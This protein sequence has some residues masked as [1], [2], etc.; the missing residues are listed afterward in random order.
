MH[1]TCCWQGSGRDE[2]IGLFHPLCLKSAAWMGSCTYPP[3]LLA[4][5]QRWMRPHPWGIHQPI[6]RDLLGR[7][8]AAGAA[9]VCPLLLSPQ[10]TCHQPGGTTEPRR[11]RVPFSH[12][13]GKS[14]QG[15]GETSQWG[16][17][18]CPAPAC[19][20]ADWEEMG[21]RKCSRA[22]EGG[23]V[24]CSS[25]AAG[26]R[27]PRTPSPKFGY[28]CATRPRLAGSGR[29][30]LVEAGSESRC[31]PRFCCW[32]ISF[33]TIGSFDPVMWAKSCRCS[34]C[35]PS[36][37]LKKTP[38]CNQQCARQSHTAAD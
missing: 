12:G 33:E 35:A 30:A 29:L 10:A 21:F 5:E 24:S 32:V 2:L 1:P 15:L 9:Q 27:C 3:L 8:A 6:C 38:R 25:R 34:H 36:A 31:P 4:A 17:N 14:G 11:L 26:A 23:W 28:R 13:E 20:Q 18:L 16:G 19:R 7:V 22:N 37:G